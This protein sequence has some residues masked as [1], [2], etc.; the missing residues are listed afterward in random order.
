MSSSLLVVLLSE[1]LQT[2]K[3]IANGYDPGKSGGKYYD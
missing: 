1:G 2:L 3:P